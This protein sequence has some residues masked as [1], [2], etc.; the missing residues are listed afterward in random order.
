[1]SDA[2]ESKMDIPSD[3]A[4]EPEPEKGSP[5]WKK[6]Q[7]EH[8][9]KAEK[10]R[11][12]QKKEEGVSRRSLLK[13]VPF[14]TSWVALAGGVG[15]CSVAGARFMMP[16][17]N[18]SPPQTFKAGFPAEYSSDVVETKFKAEKRTWIIRTQ[19]DVANKKP[20]FFALQAKCTHLGC[21]PNWLSSQSIFK[22]PCHGSGFYKSGINFEGPAPKPMARFKISLEADGLITVDKSVSFDY[23]GGSGGWSHPDAFLSLQEAGLS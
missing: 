4:E 10:K 20:G 9:A 23:G 19:N 14:V 7:G 11:L 8:L 1:M 16:N 2:D 3:Q 17:V 22:C 18:F 6:Q 5:E 15:T 21:T 12:K 13:Y